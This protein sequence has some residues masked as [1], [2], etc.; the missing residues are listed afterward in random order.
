MRILFLLMTA[1]L[2]SKPVYADKTSFPADVSVVQ[3]GQPFAAYMKKL[4]AAI[5]ANKM[6]VVAQACATCGAK[7][8]GVTIPENRVVMIFN[9]HFAVRMLK[10]SIPAVAG[11]FFSF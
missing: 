5:A 7:A 6:G 8:I 11:S 1:L 9:P 2:I 4:L 10:A 3:T